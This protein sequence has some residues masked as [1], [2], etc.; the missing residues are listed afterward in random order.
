MPYLRWVDPLHDQDLVQWECP[1][2]SQCSWSSNTRPI[3]IAPKQ[4]MPKPPIRKFH[5][6]CERLYMRGRHSTA[7]TCRYTPP[8]KASSMPID[9]TGTSCAR[10][11]TTPSRTLSPATKLN[12]KACRGD[13]PPM[14]GLVR[15]E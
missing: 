10:M 14:D 7:A 8:P 13:R 15:M 4:N 12:V 9:S 5:E 2:S 3:A 6:L 11:M 1:P